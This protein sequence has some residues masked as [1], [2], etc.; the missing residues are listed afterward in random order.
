[1]TSSGE[2]TGRPG[3]EPIGWATAQKRPVVAAHVGGLAM[4]V[5]AVVTEGGLPVAA[6]RLLWPGVFFYVVFILAF[7]LPLWL[8]QGIVYWQ[9][10][11]RGRPMFVSPAGAGQLDPERRCRFL[12]SL[13]THVFVL[14]V[15]Y[16]AD[17]EGG[18]GWTRPAWL[19]LGLFAASLLGFCLWTIFVPVLPPLFL[20]GVITFWTSAFIFGLSH[21]VRGE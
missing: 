11:R 18:R 13:R 20:L 1:M 12:L 21:L 15:L 9:M 3:T 6:G 17:G 10:G 14:A 16:L 7:L 19:F 2:G 8:V 4:L 5:V